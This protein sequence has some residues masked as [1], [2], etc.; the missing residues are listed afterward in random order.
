VCDLLIFL[1]VGYVPR[2][3]PQR[4]HHIRK[5]QQ[6]R[7]DVD[8]LLHALAILV[9]ARALDALRSGEVNLYAKSQTI[10]I[11]K[12]TRAHTH[13]ELIRKWL[14]EPKGSSLVYIQML[15]GRV[16]A[17]TLVATLSASPVHTHILIY[18]R[19]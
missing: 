19:R 7:V 5:T 3:R 13:R 8:G 10:F 17:A 6:R 9:R 4:L 12:G 2:R 11:T 14:W 15:G 1:P 18:S 16:D